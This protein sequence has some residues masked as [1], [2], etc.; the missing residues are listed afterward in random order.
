MNP[1]L[2]FG[3]LLAALMMAASAA[4]VALRPTHKIADDG[5]KI[6]LETLVPKA[7]GE[8]REEPLLFAQVINPQQQEVLDRIYN[9]TLARTYVNPQGYRVMLSI[10]YGGDQSD[11]MQVHR[12]EV[13]YPAQGFTLRD[14]HGDSLQ[15]AFGNLPVT[16]VNTSLGSRQEPITYWVTIGDTVLRSTGIRKKL[17]EMS[18]GLAGKIPDGMLVRVSSIDR[19]TSRAYEMQDRFTRQMVEALQPELRWRLAGKAEH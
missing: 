9:Q 12:P 6:D 7:F 16:R 10:A 3:I 11:A 2:R 1:V 17:V 5:P 19:D 8:W 4:A 13:C 18:Y 14:K 15:T